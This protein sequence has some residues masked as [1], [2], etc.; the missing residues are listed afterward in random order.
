MWT[1][2]MEDLRPKRPAWVDGARLAG[3]A[4]DLGFHPKSD[5][6]PSRFFSGRGG[7]L[8]RSDF[9]VVIWTTEQRE[10]RGQGDQSGGCCC[11]SQGT[12]WCGHWWW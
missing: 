7:N 10:R 4:K 1:L 8:L 5:E 3:Y 12:L 6:E 11:V 9:E 2:L